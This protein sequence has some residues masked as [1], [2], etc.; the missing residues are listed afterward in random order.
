MPA[1]R[2]TGST[3]RSNSSLYPRRSTRLSKSHATVSASTALLDSSKS[4]PKK[5][6]SKPQPVTDES[7]SSSRGRVAEDHRSKGKRAQ[8]LSATELRRRERELLRQ[9]EECRRKAREIEERMMQVSTKE[10]EASQMMDQFAEREAQATLLQLEEHFTCALC[11]DILAY[12]YSLNPAQCGHTFCALCILKWFF[13]RLHRAC[14]SWHESVDCP[15]CRSLLVITPESPPRLDITFPFVPNRTAAA[16]CESLIEKL[17]QSPSP[18]S[19][20]VKK[21][22]TETEWTSGSKVDADCPKKKASEEAV[23][24]TSGIAAWRE[25]GNLRAEWLKRDREGKHE[26]NNLVQSWSNLKSQDF[27]S[28]KARLGV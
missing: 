9:E 24:Q 12:P 19:T 11:Y 21:E 22:D 17:A 13:S 4:R 6:Q 2:R 20:S 5:R 27:I 1:T 7:C 10:L 26:M 28:L 14:G 8:R 18:R 25:G 3:T 15:I 23:D 16:I